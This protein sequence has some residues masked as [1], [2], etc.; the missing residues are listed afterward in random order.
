[1]NRNIHWSL[2]YDFVYFIIIFYN[3]IRNTHDLE[4]TDIGSL[5]LNNR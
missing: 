4:K 3:N 5:Y 2:K 1:M